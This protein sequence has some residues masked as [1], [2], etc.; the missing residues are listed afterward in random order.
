MK[1]SPEVTAAKA[2]W[3][4]Q[5]FDKHP[6]HSADKCNNSMRRKFSHGMKWETV[7]EIKKRVL[8]ERVNGKANVAK[9]VD[10]KFK[11]VAQPVVLTQDDPAVGFKVA[12]TQ[13]RNQVRGLSGVV[14]RSLSIKLDET[15]GKWDIEY[16]LANKENQ[17]SL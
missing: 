4:E 16:D 9:S 1:E 10:K 14:L 7:Q 17:V 3:V 15:T 12:L 8:S 13:F 11:L 5:Y 6:G 2:Q